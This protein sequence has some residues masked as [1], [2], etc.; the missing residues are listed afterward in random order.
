MKVGDLVSWVEHLTQEGELVLTG[1]VVF[2]RE[3][4]RAAKVLCDGEVICRSVSM[5]ELVNHAN[6]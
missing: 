6:R 4:A 2:Y 3:G 5:M 1:L